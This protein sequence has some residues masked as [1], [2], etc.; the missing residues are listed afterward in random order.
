PSAPFCIPSSPRRCARGV[1]SPCLPLLPCCC[2]LET[3]GLGRTEVVR[4]AGRPARG[5]RRRIRA[6]RSAGKRP[7]GAASWKTA[8]ARRGSVLRGGRLRRAAVAF[9]CFRRRFGRR[10]VDLDVVV[11]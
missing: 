9:G 2:Y 1:P 5:R 7:G 6:P 4:R 3:C 10:V 11:L 8:R